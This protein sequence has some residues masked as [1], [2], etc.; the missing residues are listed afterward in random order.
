MR[1]ASSNSA[2]IADLRVSDHARSFSHY[3]AAFLEQRRRSHLAV[4]SS[5]TNHDLS[6]SFA[7]AGEVGN[8]TNVDEDA[9]LAQP[10]LHQR[11]ETVAAGYEL[12]AAAC[13]LQLRDGIVERRCTDVFEC[14][15]DHAFPP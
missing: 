10:E 14:R 15:R 3:G 5:G 2:A 7:D 4:H 1:D 11:N 9:G 13:R 12:G 6:V 8:A